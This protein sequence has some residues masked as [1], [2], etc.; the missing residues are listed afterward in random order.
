[1]KSLVKVETKPDEIMKEIGRLKEK[2]ISLTLTKVSSFLTSPVTREKLMHWRETECPIIQGN[3]DHV[4]ATFLAKALYKIREAINQWDG[5]L[6]VFE[7]MQKRILDVF[8]TR[9][10]NIEG[11]LANIENNLVNGDM[12]Y[13]D[14]SSTSSEESDYVNMGFSFKFQVALAMSSNVPFGDV[15]DHSSLMYLEEK[16]PQRKNLEEYIVYYQN[17]KAQEMREIT[18][19]VLNG[20]LKDI[21]IKAILKDKVEHFVDLLNGLVQNVPSLIQADKDMVEN[22]MLGC[23]ESDDK[24][25][26][27]YWDKYSEAHTL[28]G[29]L[30]H[31]YMSELRRYDIEVA[32]IMNWGDVIAEG[33]YGKVQLASL[34]TRNDET[35][36]VAVKLMK[37]E[38]TPRNATGFVAEEESLR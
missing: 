23:E 7:N 18:E 27:I 38:L 9:F 32:Q 1:M 30:D 4:N 15:L 29:E 3:L 5:Q 37:E 11:Q 8:K 24:I 36:K 31:L 25:Y 35:T 28:I 13:S 34:Q 26:S 2:E 21:G 19:I 6:Q 17:H 22:I 16:L 33:T 20:L 10:A 14:G 12:I